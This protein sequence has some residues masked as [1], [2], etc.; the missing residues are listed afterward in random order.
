M[1]GGASP[2]ASATGA[3]GSCSIG[4]SQYGQTCQSA[5]SGLLQIGAR[6]AQLGRAD[7]ADEEVLVDLGPAD[8]AVQIAGAEPL[9]HR[10]DLEL[11]LAHVL[12]VLGRPEQHVDERADERDE[13]ERG[14]DPDEQPVL[15]AAPRVL[16]DPVDGR[17]PEDDHEED[18]EVPDHV[19]R[20]RVEEVV[21]AAEGGRGHRRILP[22]P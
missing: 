12:E 13:A 17:D 6:L 14:R 22:S 1:R 15:D 2:S 7:R 20:R 21:D 11:A 19:P 16:V 9:L 18:R 5:S 4:V 3:S 8:R 10:P